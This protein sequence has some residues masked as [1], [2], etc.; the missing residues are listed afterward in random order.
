MQRIGPAVFHLNLKYFGQNTFLPPPQL[1][2]LNSSL[3]KMICTTWSLS[4]ETCGIP[5]TLLF[6]FTP[7][8]FDSEACQWELRWAFK[9]GVKPI[10]LYQDPDIYK[11][12][13]PKVPQDL[14]AILNNIGLQYIGTEHL[15]QATN[16][17]IFDIMGYSSTATTVVVSSSASA[18]P[19]GHSPVVPLH[20]PFTQVHTAQE[21]EQLD[22]EGVYQL[23]QKWGLKRYAESFRDK[24]MTGAKLL[25]TKRH[26][27]QK[28]ITDEDDLDTFIQFVTD[29]GHVIP[30]A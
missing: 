27:F 1:N 13:S 26:V 20:Q 2:P 9:Y 22:E 17:K 18:S 7:G 16:A 8:Y 10:V 6:F 23:L 11:V 29:L 25:K 5:G 4:S 24:D 3:T 30:Q 19:V 21:L 14:T 15:R 28:L 12:V